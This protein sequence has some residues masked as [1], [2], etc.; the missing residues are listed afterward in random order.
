MYCNNTV[1]KSIKHI[2]LQWPKYSIHNSKDT[3][4]YGEITL[5]CAK[6]EV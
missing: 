1:G 2:H 4:Q 3:M 5:S 6:H